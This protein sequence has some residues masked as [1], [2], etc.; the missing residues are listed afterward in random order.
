MIDRPRLLVPQQTKTPAAFSGTSPPTAQ[1][2]HL[3]SAQLFGNPELKAAGIIPL[4][5][6]SLNGVLDIAERELR[7]SMTGPVQ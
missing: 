1:G 3:G 6:D 4:S 7:I 2:L 5:H